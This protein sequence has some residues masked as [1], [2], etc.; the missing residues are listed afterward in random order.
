MKGISDRMREKA[1]ERHR[2]AGGKNGNCVEIAVP[3]EEVFKMA[4]EYFGLPEPGTRPK[5]KGVCLS[6]EDFL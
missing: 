3:R 6:L 5:K 1:Q 4:R 2:A